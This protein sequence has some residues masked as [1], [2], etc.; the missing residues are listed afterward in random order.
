VPGKLKCFFP[1][2]VATPL[3]DGEPFRLDDRE[4]ELFDSVATEQAG[5]AGTPVSYWSINAVDTKKDPLYHEPIDSRAFAGPFKLYGIFTAPEHTPIVTEEGISEEFDAGL[6]IPRK[7]LEDAGV[8]VPSPGDVVHTWKLPIY[9]SLATVEPTSLPGAGYYFD[10]I[11]PSPDG[12]VNDSPT[13]VRWVITLK[14][15]TTF[16]PERRLQR[17]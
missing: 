17:P 11:H 12:Y 9:V 2:A 10:V 5:I 6:S 7:A 15:R 8:P 14:R 13:F 16:T 4:R 1:S 3:K